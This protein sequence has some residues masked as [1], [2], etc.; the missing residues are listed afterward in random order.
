MF[1]GYL[2]WYHFICCCHASW[3]NVG[4][5]VIV[6]HVAFLLMF[7]WQGVAHLVLVTNPTVVVVTFQLGDQKSQGL[8][9][10]AEFSY[11]NAYSF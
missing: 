2:I 3:P 1:I 8:A 11:L 7:I 6:M 4:T 10:L 9:E 5:C